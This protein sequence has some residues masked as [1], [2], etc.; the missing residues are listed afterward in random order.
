MK[1]TALALSAV[2]LLLAAMIYW[3]AGASVQTADRVTRDAPL[4][5]WSPAKS[6]TER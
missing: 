2:A 5:L 1:S 3:Q 6:A 4:S